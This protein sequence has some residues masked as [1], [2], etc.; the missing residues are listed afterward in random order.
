M[1]QNLETFLAEAAARDRCV[2]GFVEREF[3]RFLE[4]GLL[5]HGFCRVRCKDCGDDQ[6]VAF[7]CQQRG[8]C[9][10]CCGRRMADTAARGRPCATR[11]PHPPVGTDSSDP[12]SLSH[13]MTATSAAMCWV[14]SSARSCVHCATVRRSSWVQT[15]GRATPLLTFNDGAAQSI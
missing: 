6:L 7:S 1:Q 4:C 5:C 13:L 15:R 3:R 10:S 9:P 11:S 8:F 14:C 12:P 2:P